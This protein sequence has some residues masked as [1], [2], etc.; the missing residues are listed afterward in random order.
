MMRV[1]AVHFEIRRATFKVERYAAAIFILTSENGY[2]VE[3]AWVV[4][5]KDLPA[6]A[7]ATEKKFV[8]RPSKSVS[9]NDRFSKFRCNTTAYL[10]Q[11]VMTLLDEA[12]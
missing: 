7:R 11:R 9:S 4:P 3:C 12:P 2:G 1:Y 10:Y 5:M 8:L 6:L